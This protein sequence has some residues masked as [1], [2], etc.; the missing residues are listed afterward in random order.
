MDWMDIIKTEIQVEYYGLKP[1]Y[2]IQNFPGITAYFYDIVLA[3]MYKYLA[4]NNYPFMPLQESNCC[5]PCC[6]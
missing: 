1:L 5:R 4:D 3:I 2:F 6:C